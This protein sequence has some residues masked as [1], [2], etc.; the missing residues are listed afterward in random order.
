M[1]L[2]SLA[3]HKRASGPSSDKLSS[4]D[5][6]DEEDEKQLKTVAQNKKKKKKKFPITANLSGTRYDVGEYIVNK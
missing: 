5:R 1:T 3:S 2:S 6:L 4:T